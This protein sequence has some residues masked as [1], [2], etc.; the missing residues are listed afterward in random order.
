MK[1]VATMASRAH[2]IHDY[3]G[4][5]SERPRRAVRYPGRDEP[6]V[7]PR[8]RSASA[9]AVLIA[10]AVLATSV[11]GGGAYA[12]YAGAAAPLSNTPAASL[13]PS[14]QPDDEPFRAKNLE[15]LY[16]RTQARPSIATVPEAPEETA[17]PSP[18][19]APDPLF[20]DDS[21]S[22][23]QPKAQSAPQRVPAEPDAPRQPYPNPTSTPPDAIA[24]P[25][26]S[27]ELP[28]P[29][30]DPENPYK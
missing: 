10:S 23:S 11:I 21:R 3:F 2:S 28:T 16:G 13:T 7:L 1:E 17:T 5:A 19:S 9:T 15:L 26:V 12:V 22:G 29:L 27:P 24:P 18:L 14:W 25:N 30:L 8:D 6:V 4:H 20:I